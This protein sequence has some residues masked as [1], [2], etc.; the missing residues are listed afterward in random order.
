MYNILKNVIGRKAYNFTDMLT[1]ID[2]LWSEDK[3][4]DAEREEL[5]TL[6]QSNASVE[7]S[8]DMVAKLVEL[9]QRIKAL[10]EGKVESS[11]TA[12]TIEDY[13]IGKWYY[14]GN[15]VTFNGKVYECIAPEGAVCTWSP[16]EY[17]A[18]WRQIN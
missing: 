9:E 8:V 16:S 10:E 14:R 7:N 2:T 15:K 6:A 3:L 1:K 11:N 4:S 17:P 12:E 13:T 5:I 18:Y